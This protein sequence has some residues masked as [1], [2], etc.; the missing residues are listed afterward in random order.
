MPGAEETIKLG[1]FAF[2]KAGTVSFGS[3]EYD[4]PADEKDARL[5]AFADVP[6]IVFSETLGDLTKIS[7]AKQTDA[8]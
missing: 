3:Y 7:G 2:V 4:E 5:I 8:D 1:R 6:P